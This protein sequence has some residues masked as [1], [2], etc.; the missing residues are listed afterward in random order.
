VSDQTISAD[1]ARQRIETHYRE[2]RFRP[3][4]SPEERALRR[5]AATWTGEDEQMERL[6]AI[7]RDRP[8]VYDGLAPELKMSVGRY[9]DARAAHAELSGRDPEVRTPTLPEARAM[10]DAAL[11]D[12][13]RARLAVHAA[14]EDEDAARVAQQ[15]RERAEAEVRSAEMAFRLAIE[16]S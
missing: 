6:L 5:R 11:A 3:P 16:S 10:L 12:R 7:R 4:E 8:E 9:E 1:T 2:S 15:Q 14:G 13:D